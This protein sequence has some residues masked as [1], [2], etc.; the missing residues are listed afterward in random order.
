MPALNTSTTTTQQC[1]HCGADC[2]ST[3][4][5]HDDKAFCCDGCSM[6]YQVLEA[7]GMDGYYR[8][9]SSP[10]ITMD[11]NNEHTK[12]DRFAYL[13]DPDT[14]SRL[15][16]FT[17]GEI[18][19]IT[20]S[21]P[22]IHCASCVWLLENLRKLQRGILGAK[23]NY[24]KRKLA[25]T[26]K[27]SDCSLKDI[28]T[29]LASIGYEP[30]LN[31]DT[32]QRKSG[33][34]NGNT[35]E[36][37]KLGYAGFAFGNIMLFSFPEYLST[38]PLG[39]SF[40]WVFGWLNLMLAIPVLLFSG[41]DF[42]RSGWAAL[43]QAKVNLDVPISIGMIA[44]FSRS[45]FEIVTQSGAGFMDSFAGLVFFLLIGRWVQRKTTES[46][47]FDRDY[48]SYFPISTTRIQEDGKEEH[49]NIDIIQQGDRIYVRNRELIPADSLLLDDE[50]LI[51]YSFV[52]GEADP[53]RVQKGSMVFAG[54]RIVGR[55]V[56]LVV[57]K[58]ADAG[59]LTQLWNDAAFNQ[60]EREQ[61]V[62]NFA[63]RISA[64]FTLVVIG[65]AL[66]SGG[67]W[68]AAEGMMKGVE[69]AT[70]VLIIACPCALALSAPFT[71]GAAI[72]TLAR[73]AF[74]IKNT[75]IFENLSRVDTAVFDKTGTLTSMRDAQIEEDLRREL[76]AKD[77]SMIYQL[78]MQSTHPLSDKLAL[79][80]RQQH[81]AL[82][83]I[84]LK[85]VREETG[86]GLSAR[87]GQNRLSLGSMVWLFEEGIESLPS[88]L[89][90]KTAVH[91]AIN[92][93]YAGAFYFTSKMRT[94]IK[95]LLN[96][97]KQRLDLYLLSG[98]SE[99]DTELFKPV[100]GEVERMHFGQKPEDK[101]AFIK[102]LQAKGKRI[103]MVGDGLNDAGALVQSDF[104]L[105]LTEKV[106]AFSPASDAII[107]A[108]RLL[109]LGR[110][111]AFAKGSLKVVYASF[112][113]SLSYNI[114]GLSFAVSGLLSPLVSAIL[115]P[116]SSLSIIAFTTLS[117]QF[118][119][120][121]KQL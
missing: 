32:V 99:R 91:L 10:G 71:F 118:L 24:L 82:E 30:E 72:N 1:Y 56:E 109:D 102:R 65:I 22:A 120:R 90:D 95:P 86:K 44:L 94:G 62:Q 14:V 51:D 59:Y 41:S 80:L 68:A 37:L 96:Q 85:E 69:V 67:W 100:F 101:L 46:L 27:L 89:G 76:S 48:K 55:S 5:Y 9:S 26:W 78:A 8:L 38:A 47:A 15:V 40:S 7:N 116:V 2:A 103:L 79:W 117:I 17:N 106:N 113:L 111:I 64:P 53:L 42:L 75:R 58:T 23:V 107:D 63:D 21:I 43:K 61:R 92:G 25:I 31:L 19:S 33:L 121:K 97:L 16:D 45:A 11:A 74:Y 66:V 18:A 98:D 4:V 115:M 39:G 83:M 28:V 20:F 110:F 77:Y 54:G 29:L 50:A 57:E 52:S 84:R 3:T 6:V 35:R 12:G 36:W 108:R 87:F 70:A 93:Q 88:G 49:V 81:P 34:F 104:G 60:K 114:I 112:A 73:N 13:E 119:S 105:A